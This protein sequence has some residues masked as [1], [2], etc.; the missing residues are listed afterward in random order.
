M[1]VQDEP[2]G[3]L[4]VEVQPVDTNSGT[5]IKEILLKGRLIIELKIGRQFFGSENK[6]LL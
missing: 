3:L 5:Y 1:K 6:T 2:F 4:P